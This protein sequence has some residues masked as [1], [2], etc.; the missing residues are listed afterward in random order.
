MTILF[1]SRCESES[2]R[3]G[4]KERAVTSV[5]IVPPTSIAQFI[6]QKNEAG[7]PTLQGEEADQYSN[8]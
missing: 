6:R 2:I 4:D 3:H 5:C 7:V 1:G 8:R